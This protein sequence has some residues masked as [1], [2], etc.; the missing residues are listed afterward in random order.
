MNKKILGA[1]LSSTFFLCVMLLFLI[2]IIYFQIT[3][4][5]KMP[6]PLFIIMVII[7]L[8]P[9][10]GII[11]SLIIRIKEIKNNEEEEASKYQGGNYEISNN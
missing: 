9:I 6:I 7:V 1:I 3:E 4:V 11:A 8:M 2:M 5:D 10:I